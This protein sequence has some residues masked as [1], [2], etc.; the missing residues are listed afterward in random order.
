MLLLWLAT[1]SADAPGLPLWVTRGDSA[2]AAVSLAAGTLSTTAA[3]VA[4]S[5]RA[6]RFPELHAQSA[7]LVDRAVGLREAVNQDP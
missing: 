5:G 6:S 3:E 7:E 4:A 1:S 2:A